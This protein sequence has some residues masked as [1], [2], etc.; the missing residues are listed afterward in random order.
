[1]SVHKV[2][3][4]EV[5]AHELVL[6]A[7]TVDTVEFASNLAQVEVVSDGAAAIYYTVDGEEPTVKG[8]N[9]FYLPAGGPCSREVESKTNQPTVVRL[10]SPGTPTCSVA[11]VSE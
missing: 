11:R 10:I 4:G 3:R 8:T 1:M 2:G 5:G 7:N 6:A 9:C